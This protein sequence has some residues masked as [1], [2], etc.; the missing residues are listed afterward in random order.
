VIGHIGR[1]ARTG[2]YDV[3]GC[4]P[5]ASAWRDAEGRTVRFKPSS[6]DPMTSA[7]IWRCPSASLQLH[8][9]DRIRWTANDKARPV[10]FRR[11]P[12]ARHHT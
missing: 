9:G 4:P 6:L 5:K 8:A 12:G 2:I 3:T 1:G 7:I 11:R 10:Q